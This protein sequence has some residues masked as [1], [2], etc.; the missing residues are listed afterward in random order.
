MK[1]TDE[2]IRLLKTVVEHFEKEDDA[3]RE[4]QVRL[5]K[6]L[7]YYWNGFQRIWWS[8]VAH[9]WRTLDTASSDQSGQAEFYD[10]PVNIFRAYLESIIA[11]LSITIPSIKCW[12][13]DADDPMD[14]DTARAGDKIATLIAKHNDVS[15][16]WLHALYI[17]CTEGMVACYIYPKEDAKYGLIEQK[18][19]EDES[20]TEVTQHCPVCGE[21]IGAAEAQD[22]FAPNPDELNAQGLLGEGESLCQSCLNAVVP[23]AREN[24]RVIEKL[25]GISTSPKS[26]IC[27]EVYGQLYVKVANY[28]IKQ[29][30]TPYLMFSYETHYANALERYPDIKADPAS[31]NGNNST[32]RDARTSTQ[33]RGDTP[34]NN[35]TVRNVWLRPSAFNILPKEQ[36][37]AIKKKFPSGAKVVLVGDEFA[38]A[39]EE[40]LDE[41][42]ELT[43]NPLSDYL[44]FDP[45]GNLLTSVQEITNDIISLTLQT[46]EHGIP[47]TFVDPAV[48]NFA[49]YRQME[50]APGMLFPAKPVSGKSVSDAF[51]EVKTANLS[52]EILPFS[53][54]IQQAGQLVSGA[55]PS[56]FGGTQPGSSRTASEYA[57]SRAQAQQRL[58]TIWRMLNVWWKN[59]FGKAIPLFIDE[60]KE[61][62]RFVTK[63]E[64]GGF[65]NVFIRKSEL[66]GKIG[67]VELESS[68]EL[69]TSWAQKR[70][71]ILQ[72]LQSNN[73]EV[74]GALSSPENLP[75]LASA[76]G[77]E[78]FDIPGEEDRQAQYD[79]IKVLVQGEPIVTMNEQ[80]GE[81]MEIPNVDVEPLVDNHA[82]HAAICRRYLISDVGRELKANNPPGYKNLLLH[83]Q[84]HM[85]M[86]RLFSQQS[87]S[88][89]EQE[90]KE[91]TARPAVQ[92]VKQNA[93][94][95]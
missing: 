50:A 40:D 73:P 47:Q 59:I 70:D 1:F 25:V 92:E 68:E 81:P 51:Y 21:E 20:V 17:L 58:Q 74:L 45:L 9:D 86:E 23:E 75:M 19:Y 26:R 72:M 56:L 80:T 2:E 28:A 48:V 22:E 87:P 32:E 30:D 53:E 29:S 13:D 88:S 44:V 94:T 8:E 83:M 43:R 90:D 84:R 16:F 14:L 10:K 91:T 46:I 4:R 55:L 12:P 5:C 78:D 57:Q 65:I 77:L 41:Y 79:E 27:M 63:D 7:K 6:K 66:Q 61:D 69:P 18:K 93:G 67:N 37:E 60:M 76:I 35:V 95:E 52:G 31:R 49:Q 11:A 85:N 42:W 89:P 36:R 15:L 82:V 3:I 39:C 54:R 64:Q 71:V 24:T 33:Y 62:E 34:I 38:E